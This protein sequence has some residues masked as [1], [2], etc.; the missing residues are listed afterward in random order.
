MRRFHTVPLD[1]TPERALRIVE[2]R[3]ASLAEPRPEYGHCTNS[4]CFVGR[5]ART[6]GLF[7]DRRAFLVS[8]DPT[9]DPDGRVLER[10]LASVGPVGAGI[11]LEYYFSTVDQAHFGAGSK[12]PHNVTGLVGVMDG[13]ESDLRT[14]LPY[15]TVDVHEPMRLLFIVEASP[16][17]LLQVVDGRPEVGRLVAGGWVGLVSRDPE[18]GALAIFE[19]GGFEPYTPSADPVPR[20][21]RSVDA[22][23]GHRAA[24]APS[25]LGEV[26]RPGESSHE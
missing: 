25:L 9:T 21:A 23:R 17:R 6:R 8:Y 2:A 3:S 1:V 16:Q 20:F 4:L 15:Q 26:E 12:L 18:T 7:L 22:Y 24:I 19:G 10:L 13:H 11:N 5:R 14:G